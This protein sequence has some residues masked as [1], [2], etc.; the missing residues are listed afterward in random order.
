MFCGKLHRRIGQAAR[1]RDLS[2]DAG[3][4]ELGAV[5]GV[6][7]ARLRAR[8]GTRGE[9]QRVT[10][11]GDRYVSAWR[12]PHSRH[13]DATPRPLS[14]GKF[15]RML[16]ARRAALGAL[17]ARAEVAGE[18]EELAATRIAHL[19]RTEVGGG[20]VWWAHG[21]VAAGSSSAAKAHQSSNTSSIV[22]AGGGARTFRARVFSS[23]SRR[24]PARA[25][26][27]HFLRDLWNA[28]CSR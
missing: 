13:P 20:G 25:P 15:Q 4:R 22:G 11:L 9:S 16:D 8:G 1:E 14:T 5:A 3:E 18:R 23:P 27:A 7:S 2:A 24:L 19:D 26:L 17:A 6:A 28:R 10:S 12:R 21:F